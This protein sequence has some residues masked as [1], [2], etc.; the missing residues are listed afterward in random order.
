MS[1][2]IKAHD[3]EGIVN[4]D[5]RDI[6][7]GGP[8]GADLAAGGAPDSLPAEAEVPERDPLEELEELIQNRLHE[9]ERKAQALEKE[10]YEKGYAQGEKDGFE[11]GRRNALVL[12]EHLNDVLSG[13][14]GIPQKVHGDYREWF[15][16]SCLA[17]AKRIARKELQT[18]PEAL[19]K[20]INGILDEAQGQHSLTIYFNPADLEL[21]KKHSDLA[22]WTQREEGPCVFKTDAR[23]T[24]G[25][26][27]MESEIQLLDATIETQFAL[28]EKELSRNEDAPEDSSSS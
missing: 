20:M 21:L 18:N 5:F 23:L 6:E 19:V 16:S 7:D 13:L 11:Y 12:T 27:R 25:G 8:V 17:V 2:I 10:A 9:V 24:R 15:I 3:N 22:R 28:M 4:F 14:E 26:C 1:K